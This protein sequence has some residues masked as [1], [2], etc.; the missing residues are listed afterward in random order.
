MDIN[1][2]FSSD[3]SNAST[4]K[5]QGEDP[6]KEDFMTLLV[7]QLRNQDPLN[8]Q[9]NEEFVAQLANFS[10][11]EQME[12]L[13]E[14]ILGMVYLQQSN[15]LMSQLTQSSELIG[16]DVNYY[17]FE[18]DAVLSGQVTS[19]KVSDGLAVLNIA[20]KD[21]PLANITE[22][23]GEKTPVAVPDGAEEGSEEELTEQSA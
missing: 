4:T 12:E 22:V 13:N 15:A 10:S 23:L 1:G 3:I 20:G 17:D 16:K 19:V 8:P 6:D 21:V 14:N 11:L 5:V 9:S 7:Q 2:I 18:Q